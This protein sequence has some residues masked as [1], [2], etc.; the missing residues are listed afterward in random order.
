[1][2]TVLSKVALSYNKSLETR[3][4]LTKSVTAALINFFGNLLNQSLFEK[5]SKLNFQRAG[6]FAVYAACLSFIIHHWFES[7]SFLFF[8]FC[9]VSILN[10]IIDQDIIP[11]THRFTLTTTGICFLIN[12]R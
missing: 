4:I 12:S 2:P 11:L 7:I 1:M 9:Q 8:F 6:K 3:P 10:S 5:N